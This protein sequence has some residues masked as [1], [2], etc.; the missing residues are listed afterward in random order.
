MLNPFR[1]IAVVPIEKK[2][3]LA[4]EY[5]EQALAVVEKL[6]NDSIIEIEQRI[7]FAVQQGR[8]SVLVAEIPINIELKNEIKALRKYFEDQGFKIEIYKNDH[9][10]NLRLNW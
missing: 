7:K 1:T 4:D 10:I 2:R 5:R 9:R 3:T 6:L 8:F